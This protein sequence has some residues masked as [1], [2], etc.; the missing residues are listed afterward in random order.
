MSASGEDSE[1]PIAR[2]FTARGSRLLVYASEWRDAPLGRRCRVLLAGVADV[3]DADDSQFAT[4]LRAAV[5][6]AVDDCYERSNEARRLS[7][8]LAEHNGGRERADACALQGCRP[9]AFIT[10]T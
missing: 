2:A 9:A 8:S 10:I 1:L 4:G 5:T 6:R 7:A 3:Y